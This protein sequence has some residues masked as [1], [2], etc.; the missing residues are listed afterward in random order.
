MIKKHVFNPNYT[1][2]NLIAVFD[3]IAQTLYKSYNVLLWYPNNHL[4]NRIRWY[5]LLNLSNQKF[6]I[7]MQC[8]N[9][10]LQILLILKHFQ[11]IFNRNPLREHNR[12]EL[13]IFIPLPIQKQSLICANAPAFLRR[14]HFHILHLHSLLFFPFQIQRIAPG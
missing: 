2:F 10:R 14:R 9:Q 4:L 7:N 12:V 5:R 11:T 1:L 3:L 13:Q 8:H 6:I